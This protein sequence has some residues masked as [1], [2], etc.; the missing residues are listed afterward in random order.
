MASHENNLAAYNA[1][2]A[3]YDVTPLVATHNLEA[4][5][6]IIIQLGGALVATH[7][8]Q[9]LN[10]IVDIVDPGT[11]LVSTH[12]LQA[13]NEWLNLLGGI[14]GFIKIQLDVSGYVDCIPT[15][16]GKS[17][18]DDAA[19]IGNLQAYDN[20]KRVWEVKTVSQVVAASAMTIPTGDGAGT[21]TAKSTYHEGNNL[22]TLN[23]IIDLL[24]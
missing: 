5:N 14:P 6:E 17:V 16:I 23:E 4:L 19:P 3:H 15:D 7:N 10:E 18:Q 9:A 11:G 22:A 2:I 1:I 13:L 8:L 20:A 12:N 24:P 21:A